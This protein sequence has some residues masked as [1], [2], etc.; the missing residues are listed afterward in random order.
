MP[1]P[2]MQTSAC[3]S[4]MSGRSSRSGE[5]AIQTEVV[6]PLSVVIAIASPR[7]CRASRHREADDAS[8]DG[9]NRVQPDVVAVN[10]DQAERRLSRGK[11]S[12]DG[13]EA[14]GHGDELEVA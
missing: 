9:K 5:V 2:T 6:R 12:Q 4:E 11:E 3:V 13:E 7:N 1:A 14:V 8:G 10:R